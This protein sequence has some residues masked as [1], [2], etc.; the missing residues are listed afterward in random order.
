MYCL[1]LVCLFTGLFTI[2]CFVYCLHACLTF[3][4]TV[5]CLLFL[6]SCLLY[7]CL[8]FVYCLLFTLFFRYW[9]V[10]ALFSERH[11]LKSCENS[12]HWRLSLRQKLLWNHLHWY[13]ESIDSSQDFMNT[14]SLSLSFLDLI[15]FVLWVVLCI[16]GIFM[17]SGIHYLRRLA[18]RKKQARVRQFNR[19]DSDLE[20][21]PLRRKYDPFPTASLFRQLTR[22]MRTRSNPQVCVCVERERE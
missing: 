4:L 16:L 1:R 21:P 6:V 20:T 7:V 22:Y 10:G 13:G 5:V 18:F 11:S 19:T 2:K 15:L 8:L 12:S 14:L 3:M 9:V 17:Q